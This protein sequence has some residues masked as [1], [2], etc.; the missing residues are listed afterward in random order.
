MNIIEQLNAK[1]FQVSDGQRR[2]QASLE[3]GGSVVVVDQ[4]GQEHSVKL[5]DGELE[6]NP[7]NSLK[8]PL[9]TGQL[10]PFYTRKISVKGH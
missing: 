8:A 6:I 3:N 4:T 10:A 2:F 9:A 5:V 1:G 7:V